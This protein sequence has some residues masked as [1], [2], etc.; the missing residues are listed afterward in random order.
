MK[1]LLLALLTLPLAA[2]VVIVVPKDARLSTYL[3]R[4]NADDAKSARVATPRGVHFGEPTCEPDTVTSPRCAYSYAFTDD[5]AGDTVVSDL[6]WFRNR[7]Q[8]AALALG[9]VAKTDSPAVAKA[10]LAAMGEIR[11][12]GKLPPDWRYPEGP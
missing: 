6:A 12:D 10:K 11:K 1:L 8:A 4:I 3:S 7:I 9:I 2:Q 5:V